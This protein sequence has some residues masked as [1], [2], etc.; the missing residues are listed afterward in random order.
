MTPTRSSLRTFVMIELEQLEFLDKAGL[1]DRER[2]ALFRAF[3][4]AC[5]ELVD[6]AVRADDGVPVRDERGVH[7]ADAVDRPIAVPDDVVVTEVLFRGEVDGHVSVFAGAGSGVG[8]SRL[9]EV[10]DE[11]YLAV[12]CWR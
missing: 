1:L 5:L 11:V 2:L 4:T 3:H 10:D 9:K 12:D 7:L 6:G 8:E